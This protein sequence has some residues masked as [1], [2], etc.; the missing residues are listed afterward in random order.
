MPKYCALY[1]VS[2]LDASTVSEK[3]IDATLLASS[4]S[5]LDEIYCVNVF[6]PESED[7]DGDSET[8]PGAEVLP[9]RDRGR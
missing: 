4:E 6:G 1:R 5:V 8:Y 7:P 2:G 9:L 3:D